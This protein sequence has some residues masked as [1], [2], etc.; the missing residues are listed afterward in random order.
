VNIP[1]IIGLV[2]AA[3]MLPASE[4]HAQ[5]PAGATAADQASRELPTYQS[6]LRRP[7]QENVAIRDSLDAD[8][9]IGSPVIG[10]DGVTIGTLTD[11]LVGEDGAIRAAMLDVAASGT[12]LG[13]VPIDI[14]RLERT[15]AVSGG[16]ALAMEEDELR[17]L[18][19][20]VQRDDQWV[21]AGE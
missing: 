17:R 18:P 10:A 3:L 20:Y 5:E 9:M 1:A 7:G 12:P 15:A 4:P 21:P 16:L 19:H 2:L 13:Q 6:Y 14:A 11:L 8:E